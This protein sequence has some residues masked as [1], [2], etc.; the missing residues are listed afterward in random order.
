MKIDFKDPRSKTVELNEP[1]RLDEN[2]RD[3]KM[4]FVPIFHEGNEIGRFEL[5]YTDYF[6]RQEIMSR[7]I[8][9]L[10]ILS[11]LSVVVVS[12]LYRVLRESFIGPV[13]KLASVSQQIADNYDFSIMV[14]ND[15]QDEIGV[16]Y[17][18]FNNMLENINL[19][20]TERRRAE[21]KIEASLREKEMLLKE[22]HHRV[23]NNLQII[24][25]LINLQYRRI[26]DERIQEVL[27]ESQNRIAAIASVHSLLYRSQNLAVI[28]FKDYLQEMTSHIF[29]SYKAGTAA[30]SLV[31]DAEN[32]MLPIDKAMPLGLIINEMFTNALKY[33]F[34]DG[35]QG[36]IKIDMNQTG[37]ELKLIFKDNGIGCPQDVVLS[38]SKTFGLELVQMLVEQLDGSIEQFIDGGTKYV[39]ILKIDE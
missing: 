10:L 31:V 20:D 32:I 18:G 12:F 38:S 26:D 30:I 16:L 6:V 8:K 36:I 27:Q 24:S 39:I 33:A 7:L 15:S 14:D 25:S 37:K 1:Y 5:F 17:R 9:M 13:L 23:K 3:V 11:I 19:R 29:Q 22:I 4:I 28:N 34:P 2:K 35:R 21:E